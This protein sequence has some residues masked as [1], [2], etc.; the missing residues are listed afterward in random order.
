MRC[1]Y[2]TIAAI[3]LCVG[4]SSEQQTTDTTPVHPDTLT[5]AVRSLPASPD[6]GVV[7]VEQEVEYVPS[8]SLVEVLLEE[9]R[10]HYL[11]ALTAMENADTVRG[12]AQFER[13]IALL[14]ELSIVPDI[15]SN[16][17][18]NDLS[19]LV[20][21]SYEQYIAKIDSLDPQSSIFALREKLNQVTEGA[22]SGATL[23]SR[24]VV[25][26]TTVP[27]VVNDLV[28]RNI[29]F[30][31]G[32]GRPHMERWMNSAGKYFPLMRRIMA[33]EGIPEEI[34]HLTMVESGIN[35]MARSWARA[36]GMWQFVKGTGRLYGLRWNYWFDERRDFE[37]STRAAARHMHDLYEDLGDWYLV[38]AAYNSG[39]GRV[40]RA[41]RRSGSTDFWEMRRKLPRETRNYVPQFIAVTLIFS[42]PESYG[43]Q[44]IPPA[45]PLQY[46]TVTVNDCVDL[47]VLAQCAG[48]DVAT[49]RELNPELLQWCTP[50]GNSGYVLRIPRGSKGTFGQEYARISDDD[51]RDWIVHTVRKGETLGSIGARYGI[52]VGI[53]QETNHLSSTR[54]LSV[55]KPIVI[56]VPKGSARYAALVASSARTEPAY[57]RTR[58]SS[59]RLSGASRLEREL[60]MSR[61]E[62]APPDRTKVLY[63]VKKGDT[64]GHIAEW[65]GVR[66]ASIRNWNDVAYGRYI[67]PGDELAI[68]VPKNDAARYAKINTMSFA[69]KQALVK[70]A[71][72]PTAQTETEDIADGAKRYRVRSGDTLEKIAQAHGVSV[73]QLKRW[74]G[75]TSSRIYP[76]KTLVIEPLAKPVKPAATGAAE[77]G[78]KGKGT[79]YVVR[80]G[81]TLWS[82]AQA[83]NVQL[84]DLKAWN[85]LT[86]TKIRAGQELVVKKDPAPS[87]A[88]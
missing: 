48:T 49:M 83:H 27:L 59:R 70:P 78:T 37:K 57:T 7:P 72:A 50:P 42:T 47:S 66:A 18:F 54:K 74:N 24:R 46:D 40:Y 9:T 29:A 61:R 80:K 17:D 43:F 11:S 45:P 10:Q 75:L 88:R 52:P 14:D 62:V 21:E 3:V 38:L 86:H 34:V 64:I 82:I 63:E 16:R 31:Q 20:I 60:Q 76:G 4:C 87:T 32:R 68:Y 25:T 30:F 1:W 73:S 69:E 39:A 26:G 28:E 5:S 65:F 71:A 8:D 23:Q 81:D 19:K 22:D 53:I 67:R 12:A 2:F 77:K 15:D 58:T 55:G 79:V 13:A 33:E 85:D 41:I 35:P 44:G 56:P 6:T 84:A 36:V 51:K